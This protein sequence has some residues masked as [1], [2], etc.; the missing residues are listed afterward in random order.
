MTLSSVKG[1]GRV[2]SV[3]EHLQEKRG[4]QFR[5]TLHL[6]VQE[7]TGVASADHAQV[8]HLH[9][10]LRPEVR[11]LV[12]AIVDVVLKGEQELLLTSLDPFHARQTRA[13]WGRCTAV[14]GVG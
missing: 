8:R 12:F 2:P 10:E 4:E 3:L 11:H 14:R 1:A 9:Q 7:A 13:I 6:H 5:G